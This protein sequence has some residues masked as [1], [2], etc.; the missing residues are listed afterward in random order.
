MSTALSQPKKDSINNFICGEGISYFSCTVFDWQ[1]NE[2]FSLCNNNEWLEQY[3]KIYCPI[4]PVKKYILQKRKGIIW[5][6]KDLFDK[7]TAKYIDMRN[8]I[9]NTS[10][11]CTFV[12]EGSLGVGAISFGSKY[13][14]EHL[15]DIII[16][17]SNEINR[18]L[19]T[20]LS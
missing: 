2:K 5:W 8:E 19:G 9:C 16:K 13:G 14:Q 18:L 6:D 10:M 20:L 7:E 3:H 1:A 17:K 12:P 11:I 15:I 4:P